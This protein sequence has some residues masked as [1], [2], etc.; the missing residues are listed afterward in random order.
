[1]YRYSSSK[2]IT[3]VVKIENRTL[4]PTAINTYLAC[5]RKFYLRYVKKFK[6][7]PSIYLL[8]GN[9]VHRTIHNYH[10]NN[11]RTPSLPSLGMIRQEL[12]NLFNQLWDRAADQL[13][14]LDLSDRQIEF[15][16]DDSELMLLNYSHWL[17]KSGLTTPDLTEARIFSCDLK[18]MGIIDAVYENPDQVILVDYKTSKK[19]VITDDIRRQ[20]V[21]YALLYQDRFKKAPDT[22]WIHFL[23]EPGN[24]TP[25][26]V[27]EHFL[28]YGNILLQSMRAKTTSTDE[29]DYPCNCG[30]YCQKDLIKKH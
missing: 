10:K 1:L 24:P 23:I 21:L 18:L 22:I 9:I 6:T 20:A 28:E 14:A 29:K 3:E 12:L 17:Y 2:N 7:R 16:H 25:I 13:S 19:P 15:F 27:D 30:G 8:R 4:S 26:H 11:P 5:P